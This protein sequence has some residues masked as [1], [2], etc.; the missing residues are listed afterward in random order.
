M[1]IGIWIVN[2]FIYKIQ[3]YM[4]EIN[5]ELI[6]CLT[7]CLKQ[8]MMYIQFIRHMPIYLNIFPVYYF[9]K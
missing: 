4:C 7:I 2:T 3:G 6:N 1:D 9:N 5:L 8:V